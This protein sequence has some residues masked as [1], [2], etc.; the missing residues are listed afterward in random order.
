MALAFRLADEADAAFIV[1]SW[2]ASFRTAHAAGLIAMEDWREVMGAQ[3]RKMLVRPGVS[4]WVAHHP[5]EEDHR[6]DLYGWVAVEGRPDSVPLVLYC[7]VKHAYRQMGIASRLLSAAGVTDR[8]DYAAKTEMLGRIAR[9][10]SR[11]LA[12]GRWDPLAAR[13]RRRS[14][15]PEG[16]R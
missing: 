13:Y 15:N 3:I 9:K 5:G 11:T 7:Y 12:R 6:A 8:Y 1:Q 14:S 16:A 2:L 10:R 4:V